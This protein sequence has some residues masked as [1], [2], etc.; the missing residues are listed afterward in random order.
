MGMNDAALVQL[1]LQH[2]VLDP[3]SVGLNQIYI[4]LVE[5]RRDLHD[6]AHLL[7]LRSIRGALTE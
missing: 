7:C 2:A 6:L 3:Y 1:Q 4:W 5:E